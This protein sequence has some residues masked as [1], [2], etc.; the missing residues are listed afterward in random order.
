MPTN[1]IDLLKERF[2]EQLSPVRIYLFGS[3]AEGREQPDSDFDF[4][5]V[6]D[7]ALY[8]KPDF[9]IIT[10]GCCV[11]CTMQQPCCYFTLLLLQIQL[12]LHQQACCHEVD[13]TEGDRDDKVHP[14]IAHRGGR[15][16]RPDIRRVDGDVDQIAK[17][18]HAA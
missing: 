5:I 12:F 14:Q 17:A 11:V 8:P 7:D 1:E 18:C 13:H 2:I 16:C 9:S 3:F 15:G 6:V 10:N 4:Y